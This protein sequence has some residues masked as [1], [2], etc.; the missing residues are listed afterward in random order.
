MADDKCKARIV[1][2]LRETEQLVGRDVE[3]VE[4][5]DKDL[6]RWRLRIKFKPDTPIQKGIEAYAQRLADPAK[7]AMDVRVH[8]SKAYPN[9][10]P[11]VTIAEPR[12]AFESCNFVSFGG[13]LNTP[14]LSVDWNSFLTMRD[15]IQDVT[16]KLLGSGAEVDVPRR[17]IRPYHEKPF[18]Q[19]PVSFQKQD[20]PTV[21][22]FERQ[23]VMK[24]ASTISKEVQEKLQLSDRISFSPALMNELYA[25]QNELPLIFEIQ[26]HNG[27]VRHA[28]ISD[29]F[30]FIDYVPQDTV[31]VPDW[32]MEEFRFSLSAAPPC[33]VRCVS[34]QAARRALLQP[35]GNGFYEDIKDEAGLNSAFEN[36]K[37]TALTA[38]S[39]VRIRVPGTDRVHM[40]EVLDVYP[41][42]AVRLISADF[43]QEIKCKVTFVPAPD[44]EDAEDK[45]QRLET[46]EA[47]I[48]ENEKKKTDRE[49][50]LAEKAR[51]AK[52]NRIAM[53][54][55]ELEDAGVL[56]RKG[57]VAVKLT[58]PDGS[59]VDGSFTAGR[60]VRDM[61]EFAM[62]AS[63]WVVDDVVTLPN[64]M[65]LTVFPKPQELSPDDEISKSLHRSRILVQKR[66]PEVDDASE[67]GDD[68]ESDDAESDPSNHHDDFAP[69]SAPS[70]P[71]KDA[72]P[73]HSEDHLSKAWDLA[74]ENE[75]L[76]KRMQE[77]PGLFADGAADGKQSCDDVETFVPTDS[78]A[79]EKIEQVRGVVGA[80]VDPDSVRS[81]L[82]ACGWR[83]DDAVAL[84]MGM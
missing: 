25:E 78:D 61:V 64:V 8:F 45:T 53:L 55:C 4:L 68:S 54:R 65:L 41:P 52:L 33:T 38:H 84:L 47:K 60:K 57:D 5:I 12:I 7:K 16:M 24:A 67:R 51:V 81:V 2:E 35:R 13:K 62:V 9:Y 49:S 26:S 37:L 59:Q 48:R 21:N 80:D 22:K 19:D 31:I 32:V 69:L 20:F 3:S 44:F 34:L 70:M 72:A 71:R 36:S 42:G 6:M 11:E 66:Y 77:N 10:P 39:G 17:T 14:L 15:V 63:D 29:A 40:M 46:V 1:Q 23:M 82:E 56:R 28:G 30:A 83:V 50:A 18:D 75:E 76:R 58:F 43:T 79:Q 74:N 27:Q 73:E